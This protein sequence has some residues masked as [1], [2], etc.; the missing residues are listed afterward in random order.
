MGQAGKGSGASIALCLHLPGPQQRRQEPPWALDTH[1]PVC[2]GTER[3]L[4]PEFIQC[5]C[6]V[7]LAPDPQNREMASES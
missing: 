6:A 1:L 5:N 3:G 2:A 7:L 4:P